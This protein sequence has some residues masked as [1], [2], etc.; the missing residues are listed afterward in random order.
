MNKRQ[1]ALGL[2]AGAASTTL[3]AAAAS[4]AGATQVDA[5]E[6]ILA[7]LA[8]L[9]THDPATVAKVLAPEFQ[10]MRSDGSGFDA[11]DYLKNLP[12]L[13][14]K[15]EVLKLAVASNGDLLVARYELKLAQKIGDKKVQSIA[16][17]LS[18][19]RKDGA[20]WLI[21]AHANFAQIG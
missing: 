16:P 11:R 19:F 17:R 10:I 9:A 6:A 5:K 12:K 15:P 3:V 20:G 1:L 4:A 2:L 8:A 14:G 18:V 21:V 13:N 7:W